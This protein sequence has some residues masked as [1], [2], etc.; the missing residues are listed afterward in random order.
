MTQQNKTS[1]AQARARDKWNEENKE[2]R[3]IYNTKSACKRYIRDFAE[4]EDLEE[5]KGWVKEKENILKK[6]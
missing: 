3:K 6:F 2:R 1:P 5:V 4:L